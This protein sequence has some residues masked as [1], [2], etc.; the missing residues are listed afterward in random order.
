MVGVSLKLTCLTSLSAALS[1][2]A[3]SVAVGSTYL[4]ASRTRSLDRRGDGISALDGKAR[5][6]P[7]SVASRTYAGRARDVLLLRGIFCCGCCWYP[8]LP[9]MEFK[10]CGTSESELKG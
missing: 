8:F 10:R 4:S 2:C 9:R 7:P 3:S 1:R 6:V 5:S